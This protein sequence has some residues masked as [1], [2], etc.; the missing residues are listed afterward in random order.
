TA[1]RAGKIAGIQTRA[2]SGKDHLCGNE[3]VYYQPLTAMTHSMPA[4]AELDQ[5]DGAGLGVSWTGHGKRR[6]FVGAFA[7]LYVKGPSFLRAQ[8]PQSDSSFLV[9]TVPLKLLEKKRRG[10]EV[11]RVAVD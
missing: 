4:V 3:E 10:S 2:L 9:G 11:G 5:F 7:R 8:K 1:V 6:A